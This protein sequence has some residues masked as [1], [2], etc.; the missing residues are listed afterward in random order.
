MSSPY[1]PGKAHKPPAAGITES[2]VAERRSD[3]SWNR[4]R[5]VDCCNPSLQVS[6]HIWT[7]GYLPLNIGENTFSWPLHG[8][9]PLNKEEQK[10]FRQI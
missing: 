9:L 7:C 3:D 1:G 4:S 2:T 10:L 8:Y 6:V 5:Q